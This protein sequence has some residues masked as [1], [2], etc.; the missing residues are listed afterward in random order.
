MCDSEPARVHPAH[1][2]TVA[3]GLCTE[4]DWLLTSTSDDTL[5]SHSARHQK[6]EKDAEPSLHGAHCDIRSLFFPGYFSSSGD[7]RW[8]W[9]LIFEGWRSS[10]GEDAGARPQDP[11]CASPSLSS[12]VSK[13][14][15]DLSKIRSTQPSQLFP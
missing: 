9:M 3:S 12:A 11:P 8:F 13:A 5:L 14:S 2:S 10:G 15:P 7:P 4:N 1:T 6:K